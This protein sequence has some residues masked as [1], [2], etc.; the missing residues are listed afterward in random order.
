[1]STKLNLYTFTFTTIVMTAV[2]AVAFA[3]SYRVI[4][5][6][7]VYFGCTDAFSSPATVDS[8]RL[9]EV[10]PPVKTIKEDGVKKD[11]ARWFILTNEANQQFQK[12]LKAVAKEKGHDLIAEV[13]AVT[14]PRVITDITDAAIKAAAGK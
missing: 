4:D 9:M 7:K 3:D 2:V 8:T 14:G 11:S 1:M 10:L 13:G 5:R 6:T 12:A